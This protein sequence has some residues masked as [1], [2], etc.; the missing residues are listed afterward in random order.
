MDGKM[1][2]VYVYQRDFRPVPGGVILPFVL[3]TAV[4]GYADTHKVRI[5]VG[6]VNPKFENALF[7]KPGA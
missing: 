5:E 4:D 3:E 6:A 1:R 2:P 7:T